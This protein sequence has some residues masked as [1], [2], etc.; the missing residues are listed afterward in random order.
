MVVTP[1]E[2][3]LN[4]VCSQLQDLWQCLQLS[5]PAPPCVMAVTAPKSGV[6]GRIRHSNTYT[7]GL[8]T[9]PGVRTEGASPAHSVGRRHLLHPMGPA[10]RPL[11]RGPGCELVELPSTGRYIVTLLCIGRLNSKFR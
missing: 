9:G 7:V 8:H 6:A 11:P 1:G 2:S 4:A 3:G 10:P 5:A